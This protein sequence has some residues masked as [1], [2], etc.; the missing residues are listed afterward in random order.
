MGNEAINHVMEVERTI[1]KIR[2]DAQGKLNQ[3]KES[4]HVE[5]DKIEQ[6]LQNDIRDFKV[7]QRQNFESELSHTI[8]EN[9]Q[10]IKAV[11]DDYSKS[12]NEKKEVLNDYIVR[13][14]LRR[15]GS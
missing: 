9:K 11:A 6:K 14:V 10:S 3:I 1:A 13:E 12:Y 2:K 7:M 4:K 15:Y 5:L 8:Q